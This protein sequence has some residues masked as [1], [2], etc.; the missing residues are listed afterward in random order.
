M[1]SIKLWSTTAMCSA[2][3]SAA[4]ARA[5]YALVSVHDQ[6]GSCV[7]LHLHTVLAAAAATAADGAEH[8]LLDWSAYVR[9]KGAYEGNIIQFTVH[10]VSL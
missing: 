10:Y 3:A 2:S 9:F 8:L 6:V 1:L 5:V 4:S 7:F